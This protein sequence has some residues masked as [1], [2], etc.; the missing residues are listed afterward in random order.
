MEKRHL[1][2]PKIEID[3]QSRTTGELI[4]WLTDRRAKTLGIDETDPRTIDRCINERIRISG[5]INA[6]LNTGQITRENLI[7]ELET[8][9]ESKNPH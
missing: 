6:A 9:D 3:Y 2:I 7:R 1:Q 4:A 8:A 5:E